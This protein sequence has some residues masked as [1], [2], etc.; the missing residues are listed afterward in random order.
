M[1]KVLVLK[2]IAGRTA[3]IL[4]FKN[5][6]QVCDWWIRLPCPQEFDIIYYDDRKKS[7]HRYELTYSKFDE[8]G[9]IYTK[10][11]FCYSKEESVFL[12]EKIKE[13]NP[14]YITTINKIY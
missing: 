2:H 13:I 1:K 11:V 7:G 4:F 10:H 5:E 3:I 6:D 12:E 14:E 9:H 8:T